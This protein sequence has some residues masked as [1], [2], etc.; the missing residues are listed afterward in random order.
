M[1]TWTWWPH[2]FYATTQGTL[3]KQHRYMGILAHV[4]TATPIGSA[5]TLVDTPARTRDLKGS[6]MGERCA[7]IWIFFGPGG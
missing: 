7:T 6:C 5:D 2:M 3:S 1:M 4:L